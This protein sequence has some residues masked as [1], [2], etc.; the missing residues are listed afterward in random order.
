MIMQ[1]WKLRFYILCTWILGFKG[2]Q[3]REGR[4][5][6]LTELKM[7]VFPSPQAVER[8]L[9][10]G[11]VKMDGRF[12]TSDLRNILLQNQKFLVINSQLQSTQFNLSSNAN[13]L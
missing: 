7:V 11:E 4:A 6:P 5:D 2:L 10:L 12:P 1:W 8:L 13:V 3:V 9:H